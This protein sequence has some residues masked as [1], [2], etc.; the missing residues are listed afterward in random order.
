ML[1]DATIETTTDG[2][3]LTA[4]NARRNGTDLLLAL[5]NADFTVIG[6][7]VRSP[8]LDDVFLAI[9][10]EHVNDE[11]AAEADTNSALAASEVSR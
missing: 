7:D 1:D 5:R 9:T 3:S 6:F 10:G 8:T 11:F 4:K 2:I